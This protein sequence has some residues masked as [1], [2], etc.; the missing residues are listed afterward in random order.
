MRVLLI[1]DD[2]A[3]A[4]SIELMLKSENFRTASGVVFTESLERLAWFHPVSAPFVGWIHCGCRIC[5]LP[6]YGHTSSG[7]LSVSAS[8]RTELVY[9]PESAN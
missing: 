8:G 5:C 2:T 1:E 6:A 3:T 4:Q 7:K 9:E